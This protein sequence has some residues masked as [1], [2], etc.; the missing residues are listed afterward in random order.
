MVLYHGVKCLASSFGTL[1]YKKQVGNGSTCVIP[2]YNHQEKSFLA[3]ILSFSY[4][5]DKNTKQFCVP[6]S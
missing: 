6:T 4:F 3:N 1:L 2:N 5:P